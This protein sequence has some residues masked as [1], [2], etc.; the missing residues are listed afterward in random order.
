MTQ[1]L[2]ET[3]VLELWTEKMLLHYFTKIK[4]VKNFLDYLNNLYKLV[5][6]EI[7]KSKISLGRLKFY[8]K[9]F[10]YKNLPYIDF[11][12]FAEIDLFQNWQHCSRNSKQN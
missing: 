12:S 4:N 9:F 7:Y 8:L 10:V 3:V 11:L 6:S 5:M 2:I 1:I